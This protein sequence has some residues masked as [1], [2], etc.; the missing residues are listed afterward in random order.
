METAPENTMDGEEKSNF[1]CSVFLFLPGMFPV[2]NLG[3]VCLGINNK[4]IEVNR[5]VIVYNNLNWSK[6][7]LN[8]GN[9]N[10]NVLIS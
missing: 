8:V 9:A 1:I 7:R 10:S 5:A 2:K 4:C 6:E 3:R